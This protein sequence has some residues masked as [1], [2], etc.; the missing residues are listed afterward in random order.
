[1]FSISACTRKVRLASS[2][3]LSSALMVPVSVAVGSASGAGGD[4]TADLQVLDHPFGH[5][6][7]DDEGRA[8][9][10]P[11]E[12]GILRDLIAGIGDPDADPARDRG[13]KVKLREGEGGVAL[14]KF[15]GLEGEFGLLHGGS[16]AGAGG[17][18]RGKAGGGGLRVG[19][20]HIGAV[21]RDAGGFVVQFGQG[22]ACLHEIARGDVE[23]AQ[24][25]GDF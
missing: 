17:F 4:L 1:L 7:I 12:F 24:A 21:K 16:G 2:T 3:R 11:G 19:K 23:R 8:I 6:E 15:G 25:A 18:Q 20:D 13:G 10:D 5:A 9:L 14:L 22:R